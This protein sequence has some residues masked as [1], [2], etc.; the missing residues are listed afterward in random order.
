MDFGEWMYLGLRL[1][2][3][4]LM[5]LPDLTTELMNE[6][7]HFDNLHSLNEAVNPAI[8]FKHYVTGCRIGNVH[9]KHETFFIKTFLRDGK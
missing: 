4:C 9:T 5:K 3:G 6:A 1:T 7:I 2:P 8:S